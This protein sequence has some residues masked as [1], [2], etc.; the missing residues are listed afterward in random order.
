MVR[1]TRIVLVRHADGT[2]L[3][4]IAERATDT[5]RA[6]REDF[7]SSGIDNPAAPYLGPVLADA[8]GVIQL[9]DAAALLP[10][11]LRAVL[12]RAVAA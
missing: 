11:A 9:V 2:L 1:S 8:A 6:R 3:G 7:V 12:F 5:L 4:L 10:P